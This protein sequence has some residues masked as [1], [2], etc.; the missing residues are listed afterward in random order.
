M[1]LQYNEYNDGSG[2]PYGIKGEEISD[3]AVMVSIAETFEA[4]LS[5]RAYREVESY[6][7]KEAYTIFADSR[8]KFNSRILN[9]L[10]QNFSDFVDI[11]ENI[12]SLN[13]KSK[14]TK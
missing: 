4:L 14:P 2:I 10:L 1:I 12:L 6:S 3:V 9:T 5:K 7:P 8:H 11:R 13:D